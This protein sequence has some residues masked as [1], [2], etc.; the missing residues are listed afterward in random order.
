MINKNRKR[1]RLRK[2]INKK[3]D[4]YGITKREAFEQ[5]SE[6]LYKDGQSKLP[7]E[8]R[9]NFGADCVITTAWPTAVD[10][11]IAAKLNHAFKKTEGEHNALK[12]VKT[13]KF[14]SDKYKN[15]KLS[16]EEHNAKI[17]NSSDKRGKPKKI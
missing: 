14:G 11:G 3:A 8:E 9:I 17:K 4:K 2:K 15:H 5:Y 1:R 12:R 6:N 10:H 13:R 7:K 16:K